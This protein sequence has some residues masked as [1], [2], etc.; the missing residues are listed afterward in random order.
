MPQL[1]DRVRRTTWRA[2]LEA[3]DDRI[4]RDAAQIGFFAILSFV[5]L[6]L[7]LV[8]TFGLIFDDADVRARVVKTVF[9]NVPLST[10]ADRARLEGT[11]SDALRRAG[12]ISVFS[13]LLLIAA[14]SGIMGAL[15]HTINEA[16]DIH[17]RPP[18]LRR[19]ALDLALTLGATIVLVTSLAVSATRRAA[20][21]VDRESGVGGALLDGVGDVLPFV[22]GGLALLFLYCVLPMQR[23]RPRDVWPGV[24]VAVLLIG[25]IREALELYFRHLADFGA[26]YGSLG[27]LMA[28]L[29]FLYA[30]AMALLFGAEFASEWTRVKDG[31]PRPAG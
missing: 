23:Q 2:C 24:V 20:D 7:L 16:W 30:A 18:L 26:L 1:I 25:L 9:E 8:A 6:A 4:H 10:D 19:K 3:I 17:D 14:G 12:D 11:V 21:V 29:L 13:V 22:F 27:A 15:R 28:L 31:T 5:P